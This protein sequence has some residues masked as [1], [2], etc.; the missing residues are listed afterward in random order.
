MKAR[1]AIPPLLL[2]FIIEK[3]GILHSKIKKS[4]VLILVMLISCIA[5]NINPSPQYWVKT[6]GGDEKDYAECIQQTSDGGYIIAGYT[7]SSGVIGEHGRFSG[8]F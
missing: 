3:V 4:F 7:E 5:C 1:I 6:F 8:I 2:C